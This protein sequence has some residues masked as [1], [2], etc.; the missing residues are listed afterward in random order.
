MSDSLQPCGLWP[1][2]LLCPWDVPAKNS[3]VGVY[4]HTYI[5]IYIYIYISRLVYGKSHQIKV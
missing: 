2:R 1:A 5:Y 3:E 4:I